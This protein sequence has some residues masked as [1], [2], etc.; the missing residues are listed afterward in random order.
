MRALLFSIAFI[1]M[2]AIPV[3]AA[4]L[5]VLQSSRAPAYTE[6]MRGFQESYKGSSR[7][8]VLSDYAEVDVIRLVKEERPRAVLA[9][10]DAALTAA[11]KVRGIP[12][13]TILSLAFNLQKQPPEHIGGVTMA[14]SP[15]EYLKMFREMET[16]RIG[17]LYDPA[18]TGRY[19]NHAVTQARQSG[20]TLVPV[21]VNRSSELPAA[22]STLTGKIDGLWVIPDGT[23][24][25]S[26]NM[27]VIASF[28]I[29]KNLPLFSFTPQHLKIGAVASLSTDNA[30]IGR[31]AAEMI[32][33]QLKG[34]IAD[35]QP[36][37]EP[38]KIIRN[39]ND[40]VLNKIKQRLTGVK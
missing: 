29:S 28:S 2:S 39:T 35:S 7:T 13:E 14:V 5:L 31:Q 37:T 21:E 19:L 18:R 23:I 36:V 26:I 33:G 20:I 12:V 15:V 40:A 11:R 30:D 10:G 8:I 38:R 25:T 32:T 4:D 9:V 24:V 3:L 34:N 27:E 17:V 1:I 22:I 16:K 6:A